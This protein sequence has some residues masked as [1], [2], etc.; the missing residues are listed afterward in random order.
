MPNGIERFCVSVADILAATNNEWGTYR[1]RRVV[2]G[3]PSLDGPKTG[4][5]SC[6]LFRASDVIARCRQHSRWAAAHELNLLRMVKE[7]ELAHAA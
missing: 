1:S 4:G 2:Q 5:R 6:K 3:L 7:K